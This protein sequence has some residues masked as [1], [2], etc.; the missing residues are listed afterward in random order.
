MKGLN[1]IAAI[2]LMVALVRPHEALAQD[3]ST[4]WVSAIAGPQ[5]FA[6]TV[7]D[8]SESAKWYRAAFGLSE[9]DRSKAEDGSWEIVNLRNDQ[10]FIELI[11]DDRAQGVEGAR[12]FTKVGFQVSD[13]DAVA[14]LVGQ[15]TGERPRVIEYP[16]H[17]VRLIQIHDPDGNIIQLTSPLKRR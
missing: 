8:V 17:G 3:A 13:V 4:P 12:G 16:P 6:V 15:A 9:L 2:L 14:A 10:L 1:R 5:Y 11:R 7:M